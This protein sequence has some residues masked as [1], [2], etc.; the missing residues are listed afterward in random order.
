[1]PKPDPNIEPVSPEW[2]FRRLMHAHHM[3]HG[4]V[5]ERL[6]L[7]EVG[8]PMLLFVLSDLKKDGLRVTQRQLADFLERSPSTITSSIN[9]LEKRGYIRRIADEN[10]KRRNYVEITDAGLLTA[11]KCRGAFDDLDS[12]MFSGFTD[13]QKTQLT[14]LFNNISANLMSLTGGESEVCKKT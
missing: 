14:E 5:F 7:K 9:S 1:M 13:A 4:A 3:A 6:G 11:E 8:Q 12:A 10:D 2:A